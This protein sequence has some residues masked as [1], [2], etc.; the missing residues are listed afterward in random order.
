MPKKDKKVPD[1]QGRFGAYGGVYVAETLVPALEE[2]AQQYELIKENKEFKSEVQNDLEK[3]VGRPS[4][5]YFAKRWSKQLGGAKI[6]LKREDL[7]HTGAHKINNTVGQILLAKRMGKTRIIAETGAGQHGVATATVAARHGMKCVVY[8]G[9]EDIKRQSLNVYRIKILGAEVISVNSGSKTLKD[10]MNEAMRDWVTNVDDTYYI[11]G[12]VA[13]PHPYPQIVRDFNSVV[14][15]EVLVQSKEEIGKMPDLL[16]ACVGGGSNAMGLFYPFLEIST[17]DLV[18]VEAGGLGLDTGKHAAPLNAGSEGVL[19]GMRTYLMQDDKGQIQDTHSIAA[20][21]DYP[22]VGPEH[23]WLKD[24]GRANYTTANDQ[25]ALDA[26]KELTLV[27]GIMPAL[28]TAHA[29]AYVK[30]KAPSMDSE[31]VIVVNVSGR[32]DKDINTVANIEGI[33]L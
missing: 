10:A 26:F 30:K 7:N 18:G 32:G 25:E 27:E 1:S 2:L 9:E 33:E 17:T 3:F 8:M 22:G 14:G 13:G 29:L 12:S 24:I 20:G 6:Y 28:E 21:L 4:P 11:I 5:L 19:H 23:A 15:K 16:V 31:Q